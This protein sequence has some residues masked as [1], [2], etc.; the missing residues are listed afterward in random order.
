M[1]RARFP[2]YSKDSKE[3]YEISRSAETDPSEGFSS[4][5]RDST[6]G[7]F[8]Y[9]RSDDEC[10]SKYESNASFALRHEHFVIVD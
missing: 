4:S 6:H 8:L 3:F 2:T 7:P 1:R 10:G 9:H 5:A